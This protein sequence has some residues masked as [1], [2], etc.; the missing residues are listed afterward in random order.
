MWEMD[1]YARLDM[2]DARAI[3]GP[4]NWYAPSSNLKLMFDRLVCMNGGNPDENTIDHKD[5]EKA[6]ALEHTDMWKEMSVNHLEGRTAGFF[7]Y[8]DEGGDEMDENNVP[9][10]LQHKNYFD[11]DEEPFDN[12]RNAYA[13]LVWQCRYG[14]VEVPDN[15]WK[16]CTSGK[17]KTY[18][19][20]QAEDVIK[21][22]AFI[23]TFNDWVKEFEIFVTKKGKVTSGK[24]RAYGYKAPTNLWKEA[25]TGIRSWMLRLG[26]TPENS[27]PE[28][29]Q[30]LGLN[31]DTT[32][33]PSKTEG[34]KLREK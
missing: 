13:P 22:D 16:Y 5:P 34:E 31:K 33:I 27:S 1:M 12:M 21:E 11:G 7:C 30:Q 10:I 32:L 4:V 28:I 26:I 18:S 15:L 8:G 25:K 2:A 3:I 19:D 17:G 14:G 6:M 9:K 29:Q 23:Q 24:W 20:N